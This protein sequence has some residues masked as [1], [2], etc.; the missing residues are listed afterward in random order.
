MSSA[1]CAKTQVAR[2]LG[3]L[4]LLD[5]EAPEVEVLAED[6]L[7]LDLVDFFDC[8]LCIACNCVVVFLPSEIATL[9]ELFYLLPFFFFAVTVFLVLWLHT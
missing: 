4:L 7:A 6:V 1:S 9:H 2:G 8:F 3:V 5:V